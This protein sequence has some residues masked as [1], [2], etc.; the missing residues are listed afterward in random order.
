MEEHYEWEHWHCY[1]HWQVVSFIITI[2]SWIAAKAEVHSQQRFFYMGHS[3]EVR[4]DQAHR[5]YESAVD[6]IGY[7]SNNPLFLRYTPDSHGRYAGQYAYGHKSIELW[8]QA[9]L[10]IKSGKSKPSDYESSLATIAETSVV[11]ALLEAGR[12]SLEN[13]GSMVPIQ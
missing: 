1:I 4:I 7:A 2:A 12:K 6:G 9:C 10:D 13:G 11:T 8:A 5:G 3:G